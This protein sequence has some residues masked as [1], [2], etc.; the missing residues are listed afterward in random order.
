MKKTRTYIL[1]VS[2]LAS[3][4]GL[5]IR[6][7]SVLFSPYYSIPLACVSILVVVIG[8][9]L[10]LVSIAKHYDH[11]TILSHLFYT[12][13]GTHMAYYYS[14]DACVTTWTS[15]YANENLVMSV[16]VCYDLFFIFEGVLY[17]SSFASLLRKQAYLTPY[18]LFAV[19]LLICLVGACT[20]VYIW[21]VST[22]DSKI[23]VL[24]SSIQIVYLLALLTAY[25]D[26]LYSIQ[27]DQTK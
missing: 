12:Y 26:H 5:C 27:K 1:S 24:C 20:H 13:I 14:F 2:T 10:C 22:C 4:F 7:T 23:V 21:M 15:M 17:A 8:L 11:S 9:V 19:H 6:M 18:K 3:L 25:H 16:L